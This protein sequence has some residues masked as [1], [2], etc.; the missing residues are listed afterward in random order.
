[1]V[2]FDCVAVFDS[3]CKLLDYQKAYTDNYMKTLN[4]FL[5]SEVGRKLKNKNRYVTVLNTAIN[6]TYPKQI[7]K[8]DG[9]LSDTDFNCCIYDITNLFEIDKSKRLGLS[10][11][12]VIDTNKNRTIYETELFR[13]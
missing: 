13:L 9:A 1:M 3:N 5:P 6:D 11:I 12:V 8:T 2:G 7:V 10:K 4:A